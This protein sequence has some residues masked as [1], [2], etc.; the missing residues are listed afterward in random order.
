M[1]TALT[2]VEVTMTVIDTVT[3]E[4]RVYHNPLYRDFASILDNSTFDT[5]GA[6]GW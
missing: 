2:N 6:G 5:C 4:E 1:T 3:W